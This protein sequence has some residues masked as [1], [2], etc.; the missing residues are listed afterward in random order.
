[1]FI[2]HESSRTSPGSRTPKGSKTIRFQHPKVPIHSYIFQTQN[3]VNPIFTFVHLPIHSY[4]FKTPNP[5]PRTPEPRTPEPQTLNPKN[6]QISRPSKTRFFPLKKCLFERV[7]RQIW[8][9]GFLG[10]QKLV[11][12]TLCRP[13]IDK[14]QLPKHVVPP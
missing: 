3:L 5:E 4:I 1:M 14:K 8:I 2:R 12:N 13:K 10:T 9:L 6:F 7:R 11:Q